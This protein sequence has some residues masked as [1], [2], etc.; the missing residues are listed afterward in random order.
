MYVARLRISE[1][2]EEDEGR[3]MTVKVFN[4]VGYVNLTITLDN[5]E[6]GMI[7]HYYIQRYKNQQI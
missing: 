1:L 4:D 7:N 5:L 2:Y 3:E 6:E